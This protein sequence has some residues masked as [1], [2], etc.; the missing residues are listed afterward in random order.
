MRVGDLAPD[1]ALPTLDGRQVR[2]ADRLGRV[3]VL[4]VFW[5]YFCF[6][7]QKELP[8]IGGLYRSLG[9]RQLDVIGICLDGPR[10]GDRILPFVRDKGITFPNAYDR[11]TQEFFE[12]AERYGVVGTPTSFLLDSEGR[13]R[14]IHLG[15][16]DPQ[17][18]KGLL[19][20]VG[21]HTYCAEI[22]KPHGQQPR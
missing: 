3:P 11:E 21:E 2:L 13:V 22:T 19:K 10:Y 16:L 17:V 15:R 18:F 9:P 7:C 5:S 8:E 14:F 12:V 4:V 20:S 6:P 1:F